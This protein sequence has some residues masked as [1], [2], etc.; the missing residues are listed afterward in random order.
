MLMDDVTLDA[1]MLASKAVMSP[2]MSQDA[3]MSMSGNDVTAMVIQDA[4]ML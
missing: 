3:M 2:I 4:K 1:V